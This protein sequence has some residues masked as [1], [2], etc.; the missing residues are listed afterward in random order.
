MIILWDPLSSSEQRVFRSNF[1]LSGL[2]QQLCLLLFMVC[3]HKLAVLTFIFTLIRSL[4][5][6]LQNTLALQYE[7]CRGNVQVGYA[8][9]T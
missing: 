3:L 8:T 1:S 7:C 6:N 5:E 4:L 9:F 2:F